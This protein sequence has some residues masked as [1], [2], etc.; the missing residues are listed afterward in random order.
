VL[1]L[2][3]NV[4]IRKNNLKIITQCRPIN[5]FRETKYPENQKYMVKI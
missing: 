3:R 2:A 1:S 5:K 4:G